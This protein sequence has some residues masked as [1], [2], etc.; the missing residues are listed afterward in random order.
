MTTTNFPLAGS[1]TGSSRKP[2]ASARVASH[3]PHGARR[4]SRAARGRCLLYQFAFH[5]KAHCFD[6]FVK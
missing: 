1:R 3:P 4:I 2:P 6:D 5:A